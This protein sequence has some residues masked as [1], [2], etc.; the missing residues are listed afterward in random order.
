[1][2]TKLFLYISLF[3][4]LA[5]ASAKFTGAA[6]TGS[7]SMISEGVHSVIDALS[8]VLLLWGVRSS[9]RAADA[10]HPFGYGR[11][12][13]FWS[14]IVSLILFSMGGCISLYEG[15]SRFRRPVFDGNAGWSYAILGIAF[16]FNM[17]T[18]VTA[19]KEFNKHR[20]SRSFLKAVIRTK[21]PSTIIVMLGDIA[22]LLGLAIA[23]LGIF[24]GRLYHN[25]YFDGVASMIIGLILIFISGLLI[26]ESKSLLMG[27]TIAL[28]HLKL[29][30]AMAEGDPAI[31]RVKKHFSIYRSP[32]DIL[33]QLTAVFKPDLTTRQI[34]RSIENIIHRIQT[35]YP[36]IRQIFIEPVR[37]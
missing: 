27:E 35:N 10:S 18:F 3:A 31:I 37:K 4:D 29:I 17:I 24:L 13:Y 11:E 36:H 6:F 16:I 1:M 7:A 33:L 5:I 12:L 34:T 8:Q 25:Q 28:E 9:Q 14:F 19:R 21:D 30:I 32:E 22:D 26:R 15:W 23:F 20:L 2:K